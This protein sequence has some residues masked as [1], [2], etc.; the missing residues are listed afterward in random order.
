[1]H[2]TLG[3]PPSTGGGPITGTFYPS[4]GTAPGS[5]GALLP[6]LLVAAAA[7]A[8][9]RG[10]ARA[11]HGGGSGHSRRRAAIARL[12]RELHAADAEAVSA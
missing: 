6:K 3:H 5:F 10:V 1:M 7:L 11:K 2:A 12:H 8:L 9:V 4:G